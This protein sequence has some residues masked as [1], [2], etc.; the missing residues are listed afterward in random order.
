MKCNGDF[1]LDSERK[2]NVKKKLAASE[3]GLHFS[4]PDCGGYLPGPDAALRSFEARPS[5]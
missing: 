1:E 5:G 2:K 3:G 4:G